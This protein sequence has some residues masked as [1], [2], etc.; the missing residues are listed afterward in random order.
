MKLGISI[1]TGVFAIAV[2]S[3]AASRRDY[4]VEEREPFHH[5]FANDN[6]LD[7]DNVNGSITVIGDDGNTIRAD[8]EKIIR[9]FDQQEAQRAKREVVVDANEKDGVAQLY[10]NGPFRNRNDHGGEDHGFHEHRE[11]EYEVTYN[12]TIRVPR[13]TILRLHTV[14]GDVK[15]EETS[16]RFDAHS[17]NG[18][19]NM[20]NIAGSGTADT[21]NGSTVITFRENP[22]AE[23]F[24]K[25]FNGQVDV[26]FQPGL[27][28][29]MRLKTFNGSAWTDF[30]STAIAATAE[31]GEKKDGKFV[32]R[33][34][35]LS[36]VRVGSGGPELKFETFNG[37]IRIRKLSR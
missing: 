30:D 16:G 11:R 28:A 1:A 3:Q 34:N 12:F 26:G 15:T 8:G 18:K 22:K 37:N 2:L 25:S 19:I 17:I 4:K 9:A 27:S 24:F 33:S 10:V 36:S 29:D 14:N 7:V 20:T 21:L 5:T 13:A 23:S 32:Y 35:R 6:S 31:P